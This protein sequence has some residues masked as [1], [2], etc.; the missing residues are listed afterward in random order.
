MS[1]RSSSVASSPKRAQ[2]VAPSDWVSEDEDD[3][4]TETSKAKHESF[5]KQRKQH[6][7]LEGKFM[8]SDAPDIDDSDNQTRSN[9]DADDSSEGEPMDGWSDVHRNGTAGPTD[10]APRGRRARF[11]AG[12]DETNASEMEL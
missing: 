11:A 8:H 7:R 6:Y 10:G 2:V 3:E 5:N 12:V 4:D 9:D 1:S